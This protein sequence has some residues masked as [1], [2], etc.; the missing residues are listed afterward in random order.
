MPSGKQHVKPE[1]KARVALEALKGEKT[2]ADLAQK[3]DVTEAQVSEWKRH[4]EANAARVFP[5]QQRSHRRPSN[6]DRGLKTTLRKHKTGLILA[7]IFILGAGLGVKCTIELGNK[8]SDSSA[9][10]STVLSG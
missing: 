2:L 6:Q 3:F 7:L 10:A 1:V 5:R 4:L 8:D 9:T